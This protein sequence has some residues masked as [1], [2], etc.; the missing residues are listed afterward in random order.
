[1]PKSKM[2]VEGDELIISG[3]G[4][5]CWDDE[6]CSAFSTDPAASDDLITPRIVM[7][8]ARPP[9][10]PVQQGFRTSTTRPPTS[11]C[12]DDEDCFEGS[13]D[14]SDNDDDDDDDDDRPGGGQKFVSTTLRPP[15]AGSPAI[16]YSWPGLRTAVPTPYYARPAPPTPFEDKSIM[17]TSKPIPPD[18][19]S[20]VT[21]YER[22]RPTLPPRPT[23]PRVIID[24]PR[25]HAPHHHR[26]K[27]KNPPASPRPPPTITNSFNKSSADKT[28]LVI[29]VIAFIIIVIVIVAPIVV[30][31]R[32]RYRPAVPKSIDNR[33]NYQ[34]NSVSGTPQILV[35]N[36]AGSISHL[37]GIGPPIA[38]DFKQQA[39]QLPQKKD[40]KEWYV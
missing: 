23:G 15:H 33:N 35:P 30:Y 11:T 1:M 12:S 36:P 17:F 39:P 10:N 16:S 32:V 25:P 38:G 18:P 13:G 8:S 4:A 21:V 20:A 5:G 34:F 28:A 7:V 6:D 22:P 37:T 31:M 3:D 19:V 14:G 40:L 27:E 9:Y 29:G 24:V 2:G 26:E